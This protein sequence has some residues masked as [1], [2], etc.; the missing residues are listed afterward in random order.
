ME[1]VHFDGTTAYN[2]IRLAISPIL[3][4]IS[5]LEKV[6]FF[7]Y[8]SFSVRLIPLLFPFLFRLQRQ[9]TRTFGLMRRA[10]EAT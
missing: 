7:L 3:S 1:D 4:D 10:S 5:Y 6:V 9:Y 8:P 2:I